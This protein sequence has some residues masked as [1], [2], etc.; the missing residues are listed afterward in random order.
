MPRFLL[1]RGGQ[2]LLVLFGVSLAIFVLLHVAPGDPARLALGPK[3]SQQAVAH[4]RHQLHLDQ[5][6]LGQYAHF[7]RDIV[8]VNF[9]TSISQRV[10]VRTLV[11][12]AIGVTFLLT[13]YALVLSVLISLPLGIWSA[14]R[15]NRPADHSIRLATMI[16]FG[17]PPFW[18]GL[19]LVVVFS[20]TLHVL[21]SSGY[22]S[23]L[24]GH[25][26]SLTLPAL[27]LALAVAPMLVRT[28][29][30][31]MIEALGSEYVE[32]AAARGLGRKRIVANHALRNSLVSVVTVLGFSVAYVLSWVVIVENVFALPGLGV[33]LVNGVLARDFPIV[34]ACA[35]IFAVA[36][37]VANTATDL[38]YAVLD[39]QIALS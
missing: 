16:G 35:L 30:T 19:L 31:S 32:A 6:L 1:F 13:A 14:V 2:T 29:R 12:P 34:E 36:V 9:G 33:L 20:I 26:R 11:G 5:P 22:G 28:L 15:R 25:L 17:M 38:F 18:V 3:A 24:G 4:L 7:L 37:I 27:T 10:S 23:G 21:P 8:T 39:P